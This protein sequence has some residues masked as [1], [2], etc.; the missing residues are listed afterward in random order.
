MLKKEIASLLAKHV[1]IKKPEIE[2]LIEIPPDE[3]LGDYSFPCF[4]LAGKLKKSPQ[5]IAKQISSQLEKIK[6]TKEIQEIKSIGPYINFFVNKEFLAHQILKI[7]ES[8]GKDRKKEKL[9]KV[10]PIHL[11]RP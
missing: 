11:K 9:F 3:K 10:H 4:V 7:N 8:F 6:T 2:N 5:E 1:P